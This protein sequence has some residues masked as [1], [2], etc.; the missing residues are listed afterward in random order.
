MGCIHSNHADARPN[1]FQRNLCVHN[2]LPATQVYT[3]IGEL[4]KGAF[5]I[6]EKVQH[7]KT[8]EFFAMKTVTF[9][10][11]SQRHEFEKEM[12]ILR[13]LH[14]PNIVKM[15]ETFE[16]D[17][18]FYIIMELC[19]DGTLLDRVKRQGSEFPEPYVKL[20]IAKLASVIQ[21]LHSRFIC[22]RDLKLENILHEHESVGGEIKLCDFGAS[23]L[24]RMGVTMRK[25]LGSVVYMAP[26]V[27]EG[28]YTQ[29][30][31]LWSLGVIMYMLLSNAPPFYGPTEDELIEKIF[32]ANV[33]FD[34][35]VWQQVSPEAKALIR[36]LLNPDATSRYTASQV[37]AHPWIKSLCQD[38][39]TTV[40][41]EF[42][43]RLKAFCNYS[44][45]QRAALVAIAFVV[46]SSEIRLHSCVYNE[47]N[48]AHNGLLTLQEVQQAPALKRFGLDSEKIYQA[49]NQQHEKGVNL[50]EFV[51]AT[52]RP[53]DVT[54]ESYLK[55][56]FRIFDRHHEG[57]ITSADLHALLGQ[58]FDEAACIEMVK[59]TDADRDGK[60]GYDD[61]A[62]LVKA[63]TRFQ[64]NTN[65]KASGSKTPTNAGNVTPTRSDPGSSPFRKRNSLV[66]RSSSSV[67]LEVVSHPHGGVTV[68]ECRRS[69]G[70]QHL[71]PVV[72][73]VLHAETEHQER[74]AI[75][76]AHVS[77]EEALKRIQS[78]SLDIQMATHKDVDKRDPADDDAD[79][80]MHDTPTSADSVVVGIAVQPLSQQEVH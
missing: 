73:Q 68:A 4:G 27:L 62:K 9:V 42:V 41:D 29:S 36:K 48:V 72:V 7:K 61:F 38:V 35:P 40:Y 49:L 47:L 79:H 74:T 3:V 19:T 24:F 1:L 10:K 34:E 71:A 5:G 77:R 57:G 66:V 32:E 28:H 31:D 78:F 64:R 25:V 17:H 16:D 76:I 2:K 65:R 56:A 70:P 75:E 59:R 18:H 37:L 60:I 67:D 6:V 54:N 30:C 44:A 33:S 80:T 22:H 53:E 39:P 43:P 45:F 51:A 20:Q 69:S 15:V 21:Y 63:T 11:G 23:T 52:L 12:D 13:G 26:E 50:L 46:P 8:N 58:H 55:T 14:H